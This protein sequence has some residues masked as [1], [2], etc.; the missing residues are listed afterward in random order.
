MFLLVRL[1]VNVAVYPGALSR[2]RERFPA[3]CMRG[4]LGGR[5]RPTAAGRG[6]RSTTS[7]FC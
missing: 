2:L 3:M 1:P 6:S 7:R 4:E 5:H